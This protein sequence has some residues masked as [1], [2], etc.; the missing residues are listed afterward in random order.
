MVGI[1][2]GDFFLLRRCAAQDPTLLDMGIQTIDITGVKEVRD[3][4]ECCR[5]QNQDQISYS[6]QSKGR[7]DE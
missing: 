5:C 7:I 6:R 4:E 2:P 3:S 1:F